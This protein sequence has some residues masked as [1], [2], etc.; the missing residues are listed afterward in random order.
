M[1]AAVRAFR[2]A[3]PEV[4]DE[5][6]VALSGGADSLALT[7]AAAAEFADVTALVVDHG[8]Q[9]GSDEVARRA[10]AAARG[11]GT[12]AEVLVVV[13]DSDGSGP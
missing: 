5:V 13:V 12:A 2:R 8:L 6:C 7:A 1:R 10:A 4:G 3:H 9:P 11:L